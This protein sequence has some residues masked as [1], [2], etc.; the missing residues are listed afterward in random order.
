MQLL[1]LPVETRGRFSQHLRD[2]TRE[3]SLVQIG[4]D[5]HPGAA[6]SPRLL[7]VAAELNGTFA[8]FR[9]EPDATVR[10]AQDAGEQYC[11]VTYTVPPSAGPFLRLLGEVLDEADELCRNRAALL[12]LP[13][14]QE[15]VAYRQWFVAEAARQLAGESPRPWRYRTGPE[16]LGGS[17]LDRGDQ[18]PGR[19]PTV[20][21]APADEP[22]VGVLEDRMRPPLVLESL[23]GNVSAAR[24]YVREILHEL[25]AGDLEE[26]AE[27]GVSELVTNAVLHAHTE[28]V[29][30]VRRTTEGRIRIGVR[31]SSDTALEPR[32]LEATST[33]GR[34]LALIGSLS[35]AWGVEMHG[36]PGSG[37]QGKTVW[38]EPRAD[39]EVWLTESDWTVDLDL[40]G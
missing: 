17:S 6:L 29:V 5:H 25:G 38:F 8:A 22:P 20:P 32:R 37:T 9:A 3:L 14:A 36:S 34:G 31:D 21:E 4:A 30:S 16:A 2:L 26:S 15:V 39:E 1:G 10:A 35:F 11:D 28:F 40:L 13:A 12:T 7:H 23:A 33:T 19:R 18:R 24:R 27:L